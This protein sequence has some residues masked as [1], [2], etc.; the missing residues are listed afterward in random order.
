MTTVMAHFL[1]LFS[2][3]DS[4]VEE[5]L[6]IEIIVFAMI[7]SFIHN[8]AYERVSVTNTKQT[9]AKLIV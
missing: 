1:L 7:P 4:S 2:V 5:D 8:M 6:K 3:H 9:T